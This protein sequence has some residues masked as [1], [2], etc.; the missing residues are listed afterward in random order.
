[1]VLLKSLEDSNALI[2]GITV[3]VKDKIKKQEDGFLRALLA[4]LATSLVQTNDFFSS[5]RYEWKRN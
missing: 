2:D 1:M 5:I 4:P 3:T